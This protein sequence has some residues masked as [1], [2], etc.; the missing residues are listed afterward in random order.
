MNQEA[1]SEHQ[2]LGATNAHRQIFYV[3]SVK[4][5]SILYVATLGLYGLYWFYKNWACYKSQWARDDPD[6]EDPW[7]IAR[8]IFAVFFVHSLFTEVKILGRDKPTVDAWESGKHATQLVVLMIA[9]QLMDRLASRDIGTPYTDLLA[10]IILVPILLLS[11]IAQEKINV[12]CNDPLGDSNN[13]FTAA[14][15]TWIALGAIVWCLVLLNY[16]LPD[17]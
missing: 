1:L 2:N 17:A 6:R 12:S 11:A 4:K 9:A 16:I 3:V 5:F 15:Y 13:R 14:N 8:A 7:P 10:L